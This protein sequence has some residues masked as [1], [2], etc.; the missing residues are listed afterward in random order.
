V[1]SWTSF[2]GVGD[3]NPHVG[4]LEARG[5]MNTTK[6]VNRTMR[7]RDFQQNYF[8]SEHRNGLISS[9]ND[10]KSSWSSVLFS[11]LRVDVFITVL[12]PLGPAKGNG[13]IQNSIPYMLRRKS[14][15]TTVFK[16]SFIGHI[17]RELL[18]A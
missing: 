16:F 17:T 4:F 3:P 10:L 9:S 8:K 15:E 2:A 5:F 7:V 1:D 14:F 18:A 6:E 11:T 12:W 13:S